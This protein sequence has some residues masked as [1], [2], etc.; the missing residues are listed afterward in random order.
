MVSSAVRPPPRGDDRCRPP[1][2]VAPR[3]RVGDAYDLPLE[4]GTVAGYRADKVFHDLPDTEKARAEARRVLVPGGH[5]AH[6]DR[7][8]RPRQRGHHLRTGG[9]MGGRAD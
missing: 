5:H 6:R 2:L 4:D 9:G 7:R 3:F 1:P 8:G